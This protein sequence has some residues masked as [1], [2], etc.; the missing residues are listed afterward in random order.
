MVEVG[1]SQLHHFKF[2]GLFSSASTRAFIEEDFKET[3]ENTCTQCD[4][5][6]CLVYSRLEGI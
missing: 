3:C 6:S 1:D 2:S 4:S 5:Y